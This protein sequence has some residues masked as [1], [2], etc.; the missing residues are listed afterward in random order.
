MF[1]SEKL[2]SIEKMKRIAKEKDTTVILT[3]R[4]FDDIDGVTVKFRSTLD[5]VL[6]RGMF[7][8]ETYTD[9]SQHN[10]PN[11][12]C[13]RLEFDT[14]DA[15]TRWMETATSRKRQRFTLDDVLMGDERCTFRREFDVQLS[16][17][18]FV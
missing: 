11:Q 10:A 16:R 3:M 2:V 13:R 17:K 4:S 15:M 1:K 12:R 5:A 14:E 8:Y 6:I 18:L 9:R 7:L